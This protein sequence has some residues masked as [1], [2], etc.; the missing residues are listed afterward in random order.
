MIRILERPLTKTDLERRVRECLDIPA[1]PISTGGSTHS[2]L[3]HGILNRLDPDVTPENESS[4]RIAQIMNL[5]G[6]SADEWDYSSGSTVPARAL[7][8]IHRALTSERRKFI[9]KLD[10]LAPPVG[11]TTVLVDTPR[12][13]AAIPVAGPGSMVWL[14]TASTSASLPFA[15]VTHVEALSPSTKKYGPW[16]VSLEVL[17]HESIENTARFFE[18][19]SSLPVGAHCEF[20]YCT[21]AGGKENIALS[22]TPQLENGLTPSVPAIPN[23]PA[24]R[25]EY[26]IEWALR[27]QL[28]EQLRGQGVPKSPR[29]STTQRK[30]EIEEAAVRFAT[31]LMSGNG[32]SLINDRQKD[33][34]FGFDL[35]FAKGTER[36]LLEVKG[37]GGTEPDFRLSANELIK[38]Q[39]SRDWAVIVVHLGPSGSPQRHEWYWGSTLLEMIEDSR[40]RVTPDSYTLRFR[41]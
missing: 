14:L 11:A 1:L 9:L 39:Q 15:L 22:P 10:A 7:T 20:E 13:D 23:R 28:N 17:G 38:A 37:T 30:R 31:N 33:R 35:E 27:T 41:D 29:Q 8:K 16:L 21:E 4:K 6:L 2:D 12:Q 24:S 32:F 36:V 3:T 5:L 25:S 26:V 18:A 34:G 40:V 19:A